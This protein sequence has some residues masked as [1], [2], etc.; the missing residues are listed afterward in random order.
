M[1][2]LEYCVKKVLRYY[3]SYKLSADSMLTIEQCGHS[4]KFGYL[5]AHVRGPVRA[6][7]DLKPPAPLHS[8]SWR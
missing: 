7:G 8:H 3:Y 6:D 1:Y 5:G 4:C 2:I